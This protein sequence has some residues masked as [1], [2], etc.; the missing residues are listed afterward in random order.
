VSVEAALAAPQHSHDE[1]GRAISTAGTRRSPRH[2]AAIAAFVRPATG[3]LASAS[4][5]NGGTFLGALCFFWGARLL[6]VEMAGAGNPAAG[7]AAGWA[8]RPGAA[9]RG[10]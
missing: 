4:V 5:A 7:V 1:Q 3:D 9:T 6:L 10:G 8:G 2:P